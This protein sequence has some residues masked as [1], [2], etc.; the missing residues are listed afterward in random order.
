MKCLVAGGAGFIGS[1]LCEA[2]L[3]K[4]D[5]VFC[6]D[7]FITGSKKNIEH[8]ENNPKFHLIEWDVIKP[9]D[10]AISHQLSAIS[11]IYHLASPASPVQYQKY[12]IETLLANSL[13]THHL[14]ELAKEYGAK[15]LYASSSEIYGNP[16]QHPQTESYWGNVNPIGVRSCY[17]E[18]KR[19]GEAMMMA[20]VRKYDLDGRIGRIF[21][22][23]GPRMEKND[24]RVISNFVNQAIEG[25]PFTVY[26]D[27][28]QTRSFCF[29]SDMIGGLITL[30][31]KEKARGEVFNLGNP[32]EHTILE[33]AKIVKKLAA[34]TSE[35]KFTDLPEDDPTRRCPDITRAKQILGWQPKITLEEGLKKTIVYF[36]RFL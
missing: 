20:Y 28:T 36:R 7:N 35:I 30:M 25:K 10:S 15:F 6:L 17:D 16:Q 31:E 1:H 33:I 18:G 32:E 21:N 22:T 13:G 14:L 23:Y 24:G 9:L 5:E 29:I 2:L 3:S 27:G 8:L 19:F 34:S 12:P 11:S 26:G 4:G